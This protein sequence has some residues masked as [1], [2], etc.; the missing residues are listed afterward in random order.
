MED[1]IVL[2]LFQQFV[3]IF[4]YLRNAYVLQNNL[5]NS[6]FLAVYVNFQLYKISV[7]GLRL[8]HLPGRNKEK[9]CNKRKAA[10]G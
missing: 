9:Q 7:R 2:F 3:V 8:L 5:F 1:D 10:V 4:S 6:A